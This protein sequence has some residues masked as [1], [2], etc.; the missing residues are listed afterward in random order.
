MSPDFPV[1]WVGY[2]FDYQH[3]YLPD[4]FTEEERDKRDA[5]FARMLASAPAVVV[6]SKAAQQDIEAFNPD[7]TSTVFALPIAPLPNA[8]W[9]AEDLIGVVKKY[10]L[11]ERYFLI[12]NQF[13]RHKS[14]LTAFEALSLLRRNDEFN[15]VVVVCTGLTRDSRH[16]GYFPEVQ[17]R[18]GELGLGE[19]LKIVGYI[20]KLDQIQLMKR[21][22]ALIQPT[23]FEG[24]PG[25]LCVYDALALGVR[26]IVSDIP[27]NLEIQEP[28]VTFFKAAS[29][30]N[31]AERMAIAL[32]EPAPWIDKERQLE[33]ARQRTTQLG[34]R[35]MDAIQ[36]AGDR[37]TAEHPIDSSRRP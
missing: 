34:E 30:E 9:F 37:Y 23:L 19:A 24:S 28:N 7:H 36:C 17:K 13:W 22:V 29:A 35:L 25:G 21:A 32:R 5:S 6:H 1:P 2:L 11:P 8:D 31:L 16:P 14:H 26:A 18:I 33:L 15:D 4:F 3:K 12:S 27:V 10:G 20:P